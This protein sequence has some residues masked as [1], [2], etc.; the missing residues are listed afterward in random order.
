MRLPDGYQERIFTPQQARSV[1]AVWR[2]E[3]PQA[4][5]S[6][7]LPDGRCDVIVRYNADPMV[8]P[9]LVVTGPATQ[10]YWVEFEAGDRWIGVRLRPER[11]GVL[12]GDALG[13]AKDQVAL[14]DG[15]EVLVPELAGLC[16]VGTGE[17]VLRQALVRFVEGRALT[18]EGHRVG[19][20]VRRIHM[21]G[22]RFSVTELAAR[23][24][25]STR[26]LNRMFGSTVGL[27]VKAYASLV[28]FHRALRLVCEAGGSLSDAAFEAGY[29]DQAH[30]TRAMRRFGGF[31][32]SAIPEGLI[33]PD[34]SGGLWGNR[35][36][37]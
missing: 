27:S 19:E 22:G 20:S 32:P 30:M 35:A 37:R 5:R 14:E 34:V 24:G 11:G 6:L 10:P 1:E 28:Q 31:V 23:A 26:H 25:C 16:E 17:D 21:A 8:A 29:A 2:H 33:R 15:A 36:A 9:R 18:P 13:T 12:W 7:I 4:G 3:E